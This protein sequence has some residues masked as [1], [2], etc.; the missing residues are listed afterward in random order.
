MI[1][2]LIFLESGRCW[3]WDARNQHNMAR[4][5]VT[6]TRPIWLF[7]KIGGESKNNLW[8]LRLMSPQVHRATAISVPDAHFN[9]IRLSV[10]TTPRPPRGFVGRRGHGVRGALPA[11][12]PA[13]QHFTI[14]RSKRFSPQPDV[15]IQQEHLLLVEAIGK[16]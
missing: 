9:F 3:L 13:R 10:L 11:S 7:A 15:G 8:T 12:R 14:P 5:L 2:L 1:R 4:N 16:I 6:A